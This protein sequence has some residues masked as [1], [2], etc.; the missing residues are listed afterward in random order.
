MQKKNKVMLAAAIGMVA[1][2][3]ASTAVR[4][5]LAATAEE[6]QPQK[7]EATAVEQEAPVPGAASLRTEKE[8][9]SLA[10]Q[11]IA[12]LRGSAWQAS[13]DPS[14]T[15]AFRE[16]SFVET[17]E[18]GA[19]LAAFEVKD[20]GESGCQRHL[21]IELMRE[22]DPYP[23]ATTIILEEDGGE[24]TVA[25]DGFAV[26]KRYVA[27]AASEAPVA[28][29]GLAEPYTS[30]IDGRAGDL[31]SAVTE[32]CA[33]HAPTATKA[34]FDGEVYLDVKGGRVSAT[35]HLDDAA[36]SIVTCAYESGA[37]SVLG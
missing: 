20:A 29:E 3:V 23:T 36:G 37:F 8:V 7:G 11:M 5:S 12:E 21:D 15:L 31:A 26:E 19:H 24:A 27:G 18:A 2:V 17:D 13:G 14:R 22:G 10:E 30:L 33:G 4:C 16:G 28:V 35:F 9:D 6:E 32:W 25:C 34:S 1:I